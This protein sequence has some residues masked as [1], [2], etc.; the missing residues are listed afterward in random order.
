M[1]SSKGWTRLKSGALAA[2][3]L[4]LAGFAFLVSQAATLS[5]ETLRA[6]IVARLAAWSG[7]GVELSGPVTLRY[8]PELAITTGAIRIAD[9]SRLP[10]VESI[11]ASAIKVELGLRTLVLPQAVFKRIRLADLAVAL[12]PR[13]EEKDAAEAESDVRAMMDALRGMPVPEISILNGAVSRAGGG[14]RETFS[15]VNASAAISRNGGLRSS[16]GMTWR[17]QPLNFSMTAGL[18]GPEDENGPS[19]LT[20]SLDSPMI[21]ANV[22]G[23][24]SLADGPR[25]TGGLDLRI[26]DLRDFT[27]WL[28]LR[29]P[30]GPGLGAF[31]ASGGFRWSRRRLGFDEGE[32]SLDG[33]RALGALTLDMGASQP[34]ISG[35]LAFSSFDLSPYETGAETDK[36]RNETGAPGLQ[37]LN[38]LD[39][40]LRLSTSIVQAPRLTLGQVAVSATAK[41]GRLM[42]DFAIL[43]LCNG[44]GSGRIDFNGAA[45]RATIRLTGN[46]NGISAERCLEMAFGRA[47]VSGELDV[48]VDIAGAGRTADGM[49]KQLAGKVSVDG[50]PG[51]AAFDLTALSPPA[52]P[53]VLEGWTALTAKSSPFTKLQADLQFEKGRIYAEGL[54]ILA[55]SLQ[56]TG[57]GAVDMEAESLDFSMTVKNSGKETGGEDAQ[58]GAA[59][60]AAKLAGPWSHPVLTVSEAG[61][62]PRR[63][64]DPPETPVPAAPAPVH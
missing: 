7:G 11:G 58:T 55:G 29:T 50:G 43:H 42:A 30:D 64:G 37:L 39:L 15:A 13:P 35:T 47:P 38:H 12:R 45:P 19:P 4:L 3:I 17:E 46:F 24:V 16:G 52:P 59:V 20:L 1:A 27:R 14:E 6:D 22:D 62:E 31:R 54:K 34:Q 63:Q 48:L 9:T 40:D 60:G 26:P 21:A 56:Y 53:A 23:K 25:A 18:P 61:A 8:F 5:E 32:F 41:A 44:S 49:L 57:R 10:Y 51:T 36:P 2:L 28:G 33:N